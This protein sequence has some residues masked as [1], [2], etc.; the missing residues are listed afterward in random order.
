MKY[1]ARAEEG[2]SARSAGPLICIGTHLPHVRSCGSFE[3]SPMGGTTV[4]DAYGSSSS[5]RRPLV[6]TVL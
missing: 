2:L 1:L 4:G 6:R 5:P 3:L